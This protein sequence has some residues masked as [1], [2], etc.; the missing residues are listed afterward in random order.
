MTDEAFSRLSLSDNGATISG[1]VAGDGWALA[2]LVGFG[3]AV[4]CALIGCCCFPSFVL[5][6]PLATGGL[7]AATF[8]KSSD[9]RLACILGNA[10]LLLLLWIWPCYLILVVLP[11]HSVTQ[12]TSSV[13]PAAARPSGHTKVEVA[14]GRSPRPADVK[15]VFNVPSL[16]GKSIDEVK[17][18]LGEPVYASPQV[19]PEVLRPG[20]EDATC[21]F[22]N[23]E[24]LLLVTFRARSR[25]VIDFFL[26]GDDADLLRKRAGVAND[27]DTYQVRN[28]RA[29]NATGITGIVITPTKR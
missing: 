29:L 1:R 5:S 15:V 11:R 27:G 17:A 2:S 13:A 8:V 3:T 23:D 26:E 28:V 7:V 16:I 25:R 22:E 9:L 21:T 20:D 14:A 18:I 12:R 10:G 24:Q 4:F 19:P 6:I